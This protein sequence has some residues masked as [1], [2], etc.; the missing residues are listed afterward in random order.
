MRKIAMLYSGDS[1]SLNGA[2]L[3]VKRLKK[4][5]TYLS[6]YSIEIYDDNLISHE[7]VNES[8][9]EKIEI[10]YMNS[11]AYNRRKKIKNILS[12]NLFGNVIYLYFAWINHA[13]RL[14][15]QN[16][17]SIKEADIILAHDVFSAYYGIKKFPT[18]KLVFVMHNS[19]D[20]YAMLYS[21][22]PFLRNVFVKIY[23]DKVKEKVFESSSYITFVSRKS[24]DLFKRTNLKYADKALYVPE[25]IEDTDREVI[26]DFSNI[27]LVTVGTLCERKN[28]LAIIK[29]I[30]K[31]N[32]EFISLTL[33]GGG[34]EEEEYRKYCLSKKI[35]NVKFV[36]AV[37]NKDVIN[38]LNNNNVFIL[39]SHDEGLPA[40][41]IEALRSGMPII[42]TDVGGCSELVNGNGFVI[43]DDDEEIMQVINKIL[44]LEGE[45]L[46]EM[47]KK[48]RQHY[49]ENYSLKSMYSV[50]ENIFNR[51]TKD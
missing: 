38:Y 50:Y 8:I 28:Q 20:L 34:S 7:E 47:S 24:R 48:S 41:G 37:K 11:V 35:N 31:I 40:V 16:Y 42:V 44:S 49:E 27:N 30:E 1:N 5:D 6:N 22:L 36:G 51:L 43:K 12:N 18:K 21:K 2:A 10:D 4:Y 17:N 23:L 29:A 13:K 15:K 32:S 19:G 9:A 14:V 39:A 3:Y 45:E 26:H 46:A 33:V 25:G